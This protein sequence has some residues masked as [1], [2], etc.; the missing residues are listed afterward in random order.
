MS[1]GQCRLAVL[2]SGAGSNLQAIIDAINAGKIPQAEIAVV[3]SS[4]RDAY[5]V[6]RARRHHIEAVILNSQECR[7]PQEF[8]VKLAQVLEARQVD[9]VCLAGFLWRLDAGF[10]Q[11]FR[12]RI[13]NI[14]P[15]LLPKFG[16]KGMYGRRV[17]EAVL[18]SGEKE[19][20]CTVHVVDEEYDHGPIVLQAKVPLLPGDTP[21]TL[22]ARIQEQEHRLYPEAIRLFSEGRLRIERNHVTILEVPPLERR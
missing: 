9:L 1:S 6:E 16:G 8:G 18:A 12:D 2:V 13:L 21:G 4:R 11:K 22:A 3:V 10:I 15:A 7:A 19:S 17:H 5:A 14:H 20:G